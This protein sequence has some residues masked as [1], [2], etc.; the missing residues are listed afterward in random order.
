M[1]VVFKEYAFIT[2]QK[3]LFGNEGSNQF[4]TTNVEIH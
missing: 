2:I 1:T 4:Y 3:Y